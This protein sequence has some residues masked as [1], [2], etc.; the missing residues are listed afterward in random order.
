MDPIDEIRLEVIQAKHAIDRLETLVGPSWHDRAGLADSARRD[1]AAIRK[2]ERVRVGAEIITV[3]INAGLIRSS[4]STD[5]PCPTCCGCGWLADRP[6][7]PQY[8][9]PACD[10]TG[11]VPSS[12]DTGGS[13]E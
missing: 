11:R 13:N 5:E 12:P 10:G 8:D 1:E 7:S 6:G 2:D 9:C 3:L 4:V